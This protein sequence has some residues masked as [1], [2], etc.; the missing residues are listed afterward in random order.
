[1]GWG[2]KNEVLTKKIC[3]GLFFYLL[4]SL[5]HEYNGL[6]YDYN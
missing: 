5:P 1:M 4:H 3:K 2:T 6:V